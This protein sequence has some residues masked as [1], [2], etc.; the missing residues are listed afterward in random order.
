M[1][2]NLRILVTVRGLQVMLR[3]TVMMEESTAT[4]TF[5]LLGDFVNGVQMSGELVGPY[6]GHVAHWTLD[7]FPG[8]GTVLVLVVIYH[9][10]SVSE[11]FVAFRAWNT[12]SC[13]PLLCEST[14][15]KGNQ[16]PVRS[17][18]DKKNANRVQTRLLLSN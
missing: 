10:M 15:E 6:E 16:F 7:W 8:S 11:H 4:T 2:F 17:N 9:A 18:I 14:T 1:L 5:K 3:P 12:M 13:L